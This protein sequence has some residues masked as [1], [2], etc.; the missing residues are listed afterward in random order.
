MVDSFSPVK[1]LEKDPVPEL[2]KGYLIIGCGVVFKQNPLEDIDIPVLEEIEP[3]KIAELCVTNV[4]CDVVSSGS[5]EASEG[6]TVL[7]R[8]DFP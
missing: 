3:P 1:L 2:F 8:I 6:S 7:N 5:N 4:A